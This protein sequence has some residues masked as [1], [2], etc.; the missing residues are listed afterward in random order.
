[1]ETVEER[2]S[3]EGISDSGWKA[4]EMVGLNARRSEGCV[5]DAGERSK[6]DAWESGARMIAILADEW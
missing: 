2:W 6:C 3:R 5:M 4:F 1:M